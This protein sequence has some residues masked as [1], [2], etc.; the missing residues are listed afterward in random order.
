MT[1]QQYNQKG[2]PYLFMPDKDKNIKT[3]FVVVFL[4]E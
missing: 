4:F 1:M 3:N 2:E